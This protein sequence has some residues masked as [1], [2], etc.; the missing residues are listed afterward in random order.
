MF[1]YTDTLQRHIES[2]IAIFIH[3]FLNWVN[4]A[5]CETSTCLTGAMAALTWA[6]KSYLY[7]EGK[8]SSEVKEWLRLYY[9]FDNFLNDNF[10]G[11]INITGT[12]LTQ[13]L[14]TEKR[15]LWKCGEA[16]YWYLLQ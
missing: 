1:T 14:D 3:T 8:L 11:N 2:T 16:L 9:R 13:L 12:A 7:T 5:E 4:G 10:A 15:I 6:V